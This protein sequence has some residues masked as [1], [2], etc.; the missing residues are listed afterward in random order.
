MCNIL[1]DKDL[2]CDCYSV[3][4]STGES[5]LG[6]L[7]L[8]SER[9][10]ISDLVAVHKSTY[11]AFQN[12]F[13]HLHSRTRGSRLSCW[14]LNTNGSSASL[15]CCWGK[16]GR[17]LFLCYLQSSRSSFLILISPFQLR[18]LLCLCLVE[19]PLFVLSSVNKWA[20]WHTLVSPDSYIANQS[21]FSS[22]SDL[23]HYKNLRNLWVFGPVHS[24]NNTVTV[25]RN[26]KTLLCLSLCITQCL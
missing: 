7:S 14:P 17:G 5:V 22:I 18:F 16:R 1:Q 3:F 10:Q 15:K 12:L 9:P 23:H 8:R 24:L 25:N 20:S 26:L 11:A 13:A 21:S 19:M 6:W 2:C 4:P